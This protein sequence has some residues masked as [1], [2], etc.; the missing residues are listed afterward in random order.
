MHVYQGSVTNSKELNTEH[1]YIHSY[2]MHS[3]S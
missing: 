1:I 2:G 3:Q